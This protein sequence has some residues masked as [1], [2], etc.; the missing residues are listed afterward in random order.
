MISLID[1]ATVDSPHNS[2]NVLKS[3]APELQHACTVHVRGGV[4]NG[5]IVGKL[6]GGVREP[7]SAYFKYIACA[8]KYVL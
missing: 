7:D 2:A 4:D 6:S 5:L 3:S 1:L 8:L